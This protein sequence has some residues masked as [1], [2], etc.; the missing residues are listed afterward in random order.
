[1]RDVEGT[2]IGGVGGSC[3]ARDR[4]VGLAVRAHSREAI[5]HLEVRINGVGRVGEIDRSATRRMAWG[6]V[7]TV[8]SSSAVVHC[9][10]LT[11]RSLGVC[12]RV[13]SRIFDPEQYP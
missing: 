1:M 9:C 11:T 10:G 8:L 2:G 5:R 4:R 3:C 12:S 13:C 6:G 7:V